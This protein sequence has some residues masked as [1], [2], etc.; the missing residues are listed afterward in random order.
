MRRWAATHACLAACFVLAIGAAGAGVWWQWRDR[1]LASYCE[2]ELESS[3]GDRT[4]ELLKLLVTLRQPG[5][6]AV[7]RALGARTAET[8]RLAE[9][10]LEDEL[11]RCENEPPSPAVA[12][13][14]ADL[15]QALAGNLDGLSP[16]AR[17][18]AGKLA[19]KILNLSGKS[20]ALDQG[21]LIACCQRVLSVAYAKPPALPSHRAVFA[22][23]PK[24]RTGQPEQHTSSSSG[25]GPSL[26][27]DLAQ[28]TPPPLAR[29]DAPGRMMPAEPRTLLPGEAK[30]LLASEEE[31]RSAK[32]KEHVMVVGYTRE[33]DT[34]A[35]QKNAAR[36]KARELDVIELFKQLNEPGPLAHAARTEL[37]ARGYSPRQIDV[38]QHL[39]S[40]DASERLR[41]AEC[42]PGIR[43]VDAR[44]W[45][46]RL[47]HDP[48]L[49]VR[50]AAVGLLA[51]D[52]DPEVV[53]RMQQIAATEADDR[54]RE[55]AGRALEVFDEP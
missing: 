5:M 32:R 46:L 12:Q 15:G 3:H 2:S 26:G 48:N 38:G 1:L 54:I 22:M 19:M 16:A 45:L 50:R 7:V 21:S 25:H 44:F 31:S 18:R 4:A 37:D 55:Q 40:H 39:V 27:L 6:S 42:L 28:L 13:R 33:I 8:R 47:S 51:T 9:R 11:I 34:E 14:L 17:H 52:R 29:A 41:W 10:V 49:Q 24:V 30:S 35:D 23:A 43:G 53:R 20:R 36:Q